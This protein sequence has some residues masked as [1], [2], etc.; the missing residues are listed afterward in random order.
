M[1]NNKTF[2]ITGAAS[3][4]GRLMALAFAR[5]GAAIVVVDINGEGADAVAA[6]IG[7]SGGRA[8]AIR[9]DLTDIAQIEQ[10]PAQVHA[11]AGRIDGLVNNAG[12]V[13]GG[14]FDE[15]PLQQHLLT[16]RVNSDAMVALTY[17]FMPDLQASREAHLV[18]IASGAGFVG[19][20]YGTTYAGSKWAA[21][22]FSESLRQEFIERGMSN[23]AVT[24]VCPGYIDTGMFS[25]VR[26]PSLFKPMSPDY[27]VGKII[28][29]VEAKEAFV[30]EPFI[31]K[32][33]DWL[34]A[35]LPLRL[36]VKTAQILGLSD[37][38]RHWKGRK[39]G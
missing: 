22:G 38:M 8:W 11:V 24:T 10:L 13:F 18:N 12:I 26:M 36:Q 23:I 27:I 21:V 16:Y 28:E 7:K 17:V 14:A 4:I 19:V 5:R 29:G 9:V 33:T 32:T 39:A 1:F 25:G 37:S 31:L 6:E 3:G 30:K 34:R 15:V 2:L 20:P 35:A